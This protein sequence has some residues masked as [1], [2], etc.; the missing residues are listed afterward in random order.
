MSNFFRKMKEKLTNSVELPTTHRYFVRHIKEGLVAYPQGM[1]FISDKILN[2]M[3]KTF[4]GKPIY[5]EHI[6]SAT[7]NEEEANNTCGTVVKSFLN[8]Y[9]GWHWAEVMVNDE[10]DGCFR[11]GWLVSNA[12]NPSQYGVGGVHNAIDYDREILSSCYEHLALTER[13]RYEGAIVLTPDEFKKYNED[14]KIEIE[15]LKNSRE[16]EEMDE[17]SMKA[18]ADSLRSAVE[19]GFKNALANMKNE[20]PAEEEKKTEE[21]K[22]P[23]ENEAPAEEGKTAE[24]GCKNE[25]GDKPSEEAKGDAD[26]KQNTEDKKQE[27]EGCKNSVKSSEDFSSVLRN[28]KA[29]AKCIDEQM[30]DTKAS[31]LARGKQLYG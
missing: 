13:P 21:E 24:N 2:E 29:S 31:R 1:Y 26:K 27:E 11:K 3:D 4:S 28:A 12:H 14:R 16:N 18:L 5:I 20:A 8:E 6:D 9:D 23:A 17:Q 30:I 15:L 10:G 25:D 22:T 19:E 7:A